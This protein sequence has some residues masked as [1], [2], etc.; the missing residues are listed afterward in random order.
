MGT[1][2]LTPDQEA[3]LQE[4]LIAYGKECL[5]I[6]LMEIEQADFQDEAFYCDIT[7]AI[8]EYLDFLNKKYFVKGDE[9]ET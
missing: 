9:N 5:G 2:E 8:I 7:E 3:K 1:F 4:L 6:D